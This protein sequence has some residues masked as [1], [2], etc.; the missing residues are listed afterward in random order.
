M[1]T[2]IGKGIRRFRLRQEN[3]TIAIVMTPVSSPRL[4]K[5]A[6]R[7]SQLGRPG[8]LVGGFEGLVP[9]LR[10]MAIYSMVP[11][12]GGFVCYDTADGKEKW[13]KDT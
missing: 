13:R 5:T 11:D 1:A 2:N 10:S 4:A 9:L 8:D 3:L 7:L 12:S 6:S